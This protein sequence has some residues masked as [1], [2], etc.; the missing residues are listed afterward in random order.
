MARPNLAWTCALA[1]GGCTPTLLF[2]QTFLV[3]EDLKVTSSGY[4][5][6]KSTGETFDLSPIRAIERGG[7][8]VVLAKVHGTF[9][10]T[11][12]GFRKLWRVWPAGRDQAKYKAVEYDPGPDGIRGPAME[13]AGNCVVVHWDRLG[14]PGTVY[15]T[16]DGDADE[17]KCK[18]P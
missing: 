9:I 5:S 15:V 14:N 8:R 7:D 16:A 2:N 3:S 17:T 18:A 4:V 6:L 10:V 12:D 11:G 13:I 1:L